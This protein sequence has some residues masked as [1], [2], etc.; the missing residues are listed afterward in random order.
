MNKKILSIILLF[1]MLFSFILS[2]TVIA[3]T[4]IPALRSISLNSGKS[5]YLEVGDIKTL[6]VS[7]RPKNAAKTEIKFT[8][9]D[10]KIVTIN[11]TGTVKAIKTGKTTLTAEMNGKKSTIYV[12]VY[13]NNN[14]QASFVETDIVKDKIK[15]ITI[16]VS[17][18]D[19]NTDNF[20]IYLP[21][22]YR[23]SGTTATFA[24]D[25]NG[26]Y[27]FTV[28]DNT[29]TKKT[30]YYE[31]T[32]IKDKYYEKP[33]TDYDDN[34]F[35]INILY[36]NMN[37]K[38][39]YEKKQL[40][41]NA[42]LDKIRT[43]KLPNNTVT[44]SNEI[45]Y[46]ISAINNGLF[47]EYSFEV[48][49]QPMNCKIIR[50]G[51]FYLM[52][53]WKH[54]K[55]DDRNILVDYK[56]Y[57]FTINSDVMTYPT[58]DFITDNGNYIIEA[59]TKLGQKEIFSLSIDNIDYMKPSASIA[60]TYDD[61]FELNIVD[62]A[63]L[64]YIITFDGKYIDIPNN[65]VPNTIY[66]YKHDIP[67]K[68]NGEYLFIIV[69]ASGNRTIAKSTITSKHNVLFTKKL[70]PDVHNSLET[71]SL[72]KE[73]GI[74]YDKV[75]ANSAYYNNIFPSYMKGISNT[76][77]KPDSTITRAQMVTILCRVTDLPYDINLLDKSR[78]TDVTNHWAVNYICMGNAKKYI[79][80]YRDKTYK[81]DNS[82]KRGDFCKMICN[83]SSLKSKISA[84][85]SVNNYAYNDINGHYAK[86]EILKLVNRDLVLGNGE[87]FNPDKPITRAEVIYAI[88]KL[89]NLKP[90]DDEMN[91]IESLYNKYYNFNDINNHKYYEDIL[92]S[93]IGM[94]REK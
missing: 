77:F 32:N 68:Y 39:D 8:T 94:Y 35:D 20:Y 30:F 41:F 73:T 60:I 47:Y 69:D 87:N 61:L 81:P 3:D 90:S 37:L 83:I 86:P 58:S 19:G 50:Q 62:N 65:Y 79:R 23:I 5:L 76:S 33:H 75:E 7:T 49:N 89:Y 51:E 44:E 25:R 28:Y 2:S 15:N 29:G 82:L 85:P 6:S 26:S 59:Y 42:D 93:L 38:Y 27:P 13:I 48:D 11:K 40:L 56:A 43:V 17:S 4:T 67:F 66:T 36:N 92:I 12:T 63:M 1:T 54:Y 14:L 84:I 72:F 88:N 18:K 91:Y 80:G 45:N 78:L 64:D 55:N 46:Y 52:M 53:I 70:G 16:N 22:G 21:T 9:G 24:A 74:L 34:I 57:N 10:E 31:I 71:I